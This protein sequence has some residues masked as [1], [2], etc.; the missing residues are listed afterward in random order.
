MKGRLRNIGYC[1]LAGASLFLLVHCKDD[2]HETKKILERP[3]YAGLTDSIKRFPDDVTLYLQRGT[4]LSQNNQHELAT[5]DYKHAWEQAPNETNALFYVS[6]LLLV[7]KPQEAVTLLKTCLNKFPASTEF[8]RRLSEVYAQTGKTREALEL[9][10]KVLASDS[11]NFE[12]WYEKGTLLNRLGD[13]VAGI[14]AIEYSYS[15]QPVNYIGYVLANLYA[16]TKNPKTISLCDELIQ[17][18]SSDSRIDAYFIKGTYYSDTKKYAQAI[19][20]FDECI[21]RDWKF[22]DAYL[23]KGI[24][25]YE[26]R[27]F[28]KALEVFTMASTVSNA[29]ADAYFWIGRCQEAKG[30]KELAYEN[31]VKAL[32]LDRSFV[33]ARE[34]IKRTKE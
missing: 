9:Y 26:Q 31:Y 17:K 15:L 28:D 24:V 4:L 34:G 6:N 5:A 8:P 30:N 1:L 33:E 16:Y 27:Q 12:A 7:N 10:N 20:Q 25:L 32:S 11:S 29:S 18:D 2:T 14:Q 22:T 23:E 19:A 3:P 13:T 21:K